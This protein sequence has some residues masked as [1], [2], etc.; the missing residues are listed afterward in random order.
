MLILKKIFLWLITLVSAY[1]FGFYLKHYSLVWFLFWI[2]SLSTFSFFTL[3]FERKIY[4]KNILLF[5]S[6]VVASYPFWKLMDIESILILILVFLFAIWAVVRLEFRFNNSLKISI[7]DLFKSFSPLFF[8]GLSLFLCLV[9]YFSLNKQ[10][11]PLPYNWF[12][13]T[14][15]PVLKIFPNF[16]N[17]VN[18]DNNRKMLEEKI[19][20]EFGQAFPKG[21]PTWY[22]KSVINRQLEKLNRDVINSIKIPSSKDIYNFISDKYQNLSQTTQNIILI[23][24]LTTLFLTFKSLFYLIAWIVSFFVFL[25]FYFLKACKFFKIQYELRDKEVIKM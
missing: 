24:I 8:T 23:V 7:F 11:F 4:L 19:H 15:N 2:S 9:F 25:L 20:S 14:V 6:I 5:L 17:F 13:K 3:L 10:A 21:T 18:E 1:F 12:E 22:E 16:V